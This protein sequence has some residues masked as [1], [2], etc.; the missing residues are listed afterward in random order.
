MHILKLG[1][2]VGL[3][4]PCA[5]GMQVQKFKLIIQNCLYSHVI[6]PSNL[7]SPERPLAVLSYGRSLELSAYEP[8]FIRDFIRSK[9]RPVESIVLNQI[10]NK[11]IVK[12]AKLVTTLNDDKLCPYIE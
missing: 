2:I 7:L 10:Y 4:H 5:N 8:R 11:N 1:G 3:Y 6:T 12:E 9:I